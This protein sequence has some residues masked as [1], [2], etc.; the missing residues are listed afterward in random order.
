MNEVIKITSDVE[1]TKGNIIFNNYEE[2]LKEVQYI[3]DFVKMQHVDDES[4]KESKRLLAECRKV[5]D[6]IEDKRKEMKK[7]MLEPYENFE[8]KVKTMVE[9][10]KEADNFVRDQ[11]KE[12]ENNEK[13]KRRDELIGI[14]KKRV[15][16]YEFDIS[17]EFDD[18]IEFKYLNKST[19][20]K[21]CEE[22]MVNWLEQR[23]ADLETI[24][25]LNNSLEVKVEYSRNG[26]DLNRAI[27]DVNIRN[28]E[29]QRIIESSNEVTYIFIIKNEKDAKL[30]EIL[31]KENNI[32]YIKEEK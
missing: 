3:A 7:I 32:E 19:T 8:K 20:I 24:T 18:W 31:L 17:L 1:F 29:K 23:K 30:A 22:S 27:K 13:E 4:I 9:I 10:L 12:L 5:I 16:L 2:M 21:K 25:T 26:Y 28:E 6:N 14:W 11:V 15:E